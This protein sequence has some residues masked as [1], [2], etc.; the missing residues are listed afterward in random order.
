MLSSLDCQGLCDHAI[1]EHEASTVICQTPVLHYA[2]F[3]S[4]T[5]DTH[6]PGLRHFQLDPAN[7]DQALIQMD[8]EFPLYYQS[9]QLCRQ[10]DLDAYYLEFQLPSDTLRCVNALLIQ[11]LCLSYPNFFERTTEQ[12]LYCHLSGETLEFDSEYQLRK[13]PTYVSLFDALASQVQEDIAIWQLSESEDY[14]AALHVCFPN[15]WA[16]AE[17]IGRS[18]AEIHTSVPDMERQRNQYLPMLKGLIQKPAFVRFIWDLRTDSIL[19][20][21]P[22]RP[23]FDAFNLDHP[24]LYVRLE[25][26]VLHGLPTCHAV[27]FMI[28]TY[29]YPVQSLSLVELQGI[30]Q[31]LAGM[32]PDLLAYKHLSADYDAIRLYLQGLIQADSN[33][34]K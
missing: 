32:S 19:N 27:L 28:R 12:L 20:H 1:P 14:L 23:L 18:F 6:T 8:A 24:Q 11:Q 4:G 7:R 30:D 15:G 5:Y 34:R 3:I 13:H 2:P 31:A 9:K 26:Q 16:P 25:R 17:K 10:E 33:K 29:H 22:A 21:L